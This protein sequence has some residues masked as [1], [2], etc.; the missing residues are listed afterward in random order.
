MRKN[1]VAVYGTLK[2]GKTNH[3][4]M[5]LMSAEFLD[6]GKTVEKY[7]LTSDGKL[8]YLFD[9]KGIGHRIAVEVYR[10]SDAAL[11]VIDRFE[12]HPKFYERKTAKCE[13]STGKIIDCFDY[14][15]AQNR[16][17]FTGAK[18]LKNF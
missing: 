11:A 14:F 5:D 16:N 1:L 17:D 9:K 12:C 13:L 18:L 3:F 10:V 6:E 7:P 8:P 2:R 4:I 15:T